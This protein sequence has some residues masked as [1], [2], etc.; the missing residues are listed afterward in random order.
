[1]CHMSLKTHKQ[2]EYCGGKGVI[3]FA[4]LQFPSSQSLRLSF[5]QPLKS[6]LDSQNAFERN[7]W[8]QVVCDVGRHAT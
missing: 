2:H 7:K 4:A 3:G 5:C 8:G 6:Y 1:M